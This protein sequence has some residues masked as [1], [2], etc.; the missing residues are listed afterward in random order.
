[1]RL[2]ERSLGRDVSARLLRLLQ[3]REKSLRKRAAGLA[4]KVLAAYE[5]WRKATRTLR[6]ETTKVRA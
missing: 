2:N 5:E 3:R 1:V 4:G 6:K